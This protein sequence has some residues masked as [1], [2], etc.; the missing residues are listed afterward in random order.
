MKVLELP[1]LSK[2][3]LRAVVSAYD[4][5]GN[6]T[7]PTGAGV[8]WA[9]TTDNDEPQSGDWQTGDWEVGTSPKGVSIYYARIM[10][11]PSTLTAGLQYALWLRVNGVTEIPVVLLGSIQVV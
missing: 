7:D 6:I 10:V 1:A 4:V 5:N 2:Q 8:S 9:F 11:G 3:Y